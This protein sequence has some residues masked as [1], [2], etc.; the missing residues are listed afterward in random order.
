MSP[1]NYKIDENF[2]N[3][4]GTNDQRAYCGHINHIIQLN[5]YNIGHV[6]FDTRRTL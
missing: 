5:C 6:Q 3:M 4:L 1:E 2:M